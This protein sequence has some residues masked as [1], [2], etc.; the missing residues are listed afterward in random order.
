MCT[1]LHTVFFFVHHFQVSASSCLQY[2]LL[3]LSFCSTCDS[4]YALLEFFIAAPPQGLPHARQE[5][6]HCAT[7]PA[8]LT[9]LTAHVYYCCCFTVIQPRTLWILGRRSPI[10]LNILLGFI[11][12]LFC[13]QHNSRGHQ[14]PDELLTELSLTSV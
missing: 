3:L 10:E 5:L 4:H 8:C 2:S 13:P 14:V 1:F 12:L 7:S 6:C 11:H 9:S